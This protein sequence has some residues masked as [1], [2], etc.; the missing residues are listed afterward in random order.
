[1]SRPSEEMTDVEIVEDLANILLRITE[2]V[3]GLSP[4]G[5]REYHRVL[6]EWFAEQELPRIL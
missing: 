1:M 2:H 4:E 3:A 5:R 6:M